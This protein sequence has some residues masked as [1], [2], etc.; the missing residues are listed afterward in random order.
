MGVWL[1]LGHGRLAGSRSERN[2]SWRAH[3]VNTSFEAAISTRKSYQEAFKLVM[4]HV[5][6]LLPSKLVKLQLRRYN[7]SQNRVFFY[8]YFFYSLYILSLLLIF[9]Q[10]TSKKN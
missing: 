7:A 10:R 1:S 4:V 2:V 6:Q 8:F 3:R 9:L 5:L